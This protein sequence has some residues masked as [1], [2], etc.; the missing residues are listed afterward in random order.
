MFH[1]RIKESGWVKE[2]EV[3]L[4]ERWAGLEVKGL[5]RNRM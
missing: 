2:A 1:E 5:G 3:D 4:L